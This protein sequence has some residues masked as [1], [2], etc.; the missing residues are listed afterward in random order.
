M[1]FWR[2]VRAR[3]ASDDPDDENRWGN[4]RESNLFNKIYL[5][6]LQADFFQFLTEVRK[7]ISSISAIEDLVADWLQ[8]VQPNYFRRNW[9]MENQK[10]D[11][12]GIRKQ[13]AQLWVAYR[14][15]PQRAPNVSLFRQAA[16]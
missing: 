13:W 16:Q 11:V 7:E 2:A 1:A 5:H 12:P 15:N 3:L 10:K 9:K 4:T 8:D 14:K 6:I